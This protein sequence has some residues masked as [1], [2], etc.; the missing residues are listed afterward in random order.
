MSANFGEDPTDGYEETFLKHLAEARNR[1][2]AFIRAY[3]LHG[4]LDQVYAEVYG[5][6]GDLLKFAAYTLG[7]ADGRRAEVAERANLTAALTRHWF[8]PFFKGLHEACRAIGEQYGRWADK[9]SFE[10]IATLP[11]RQ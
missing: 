7:N 3:R 1:A 4:S 8:E 6:I 2:R 9:V 10:A 5:A 11:M